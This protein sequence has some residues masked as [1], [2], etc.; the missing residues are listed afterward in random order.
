MVE[1]SLGQL[2]ASAEA[3]RQAGLPVD[4]V[5]CGGTGTYTI[6]SS[7]PGVTEVQ[8]GGGIFGD[9]YYR[10]AMLVEHECAL[11]VLATVTSRPTATRI[12]CDT[13][14]KTMSTDAAQPR[15][16]LNLP[17]QSMAFSAEHARLELS[18]PSVA[19]RL[20]D[21][22]EFVVGY[23]D[24]TTMLHDE[25]YATRNGNVEIVWPILGRGKL[26]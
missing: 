23:T 14:K 8:A 2:T 11:T 7:Q 12:V 9:V 6:A 4:I 26:R 21:K 17:I 18:E 25:L 19:P 1:R 10:E 24:T 15:P 20:G 5:S 13:G 22:F 16:L 3:C